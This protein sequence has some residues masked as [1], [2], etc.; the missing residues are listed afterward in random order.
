MSANT[1]HSST[2]RTATP[3]RSTRSRSAADAE[4]SS[5]TTRP[6]R[7]HRMHDRYENDDAPG[8]TMA[9]LGRNKEDMKLH[10]FGDTWKEG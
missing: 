7:Q 1:E 4:A 8:N 9:A 10:G 2:C 6:T 3:S 5:P